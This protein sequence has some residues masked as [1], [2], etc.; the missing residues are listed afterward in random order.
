MRYR[1]RMEGSTMAAHERYRMNIPAAP[2]LAFAA[3]ALCTLSACDDEH[4]DAGPMRSES[5]DIESF[6]SID[7]EGAARL[8][9]TVGKP[10]SLTLEGRER[11]IERVSASVRGDT[12]YIKTKPKDW[13]FSP[14]RQ[15]LTINISVPRLDSL[16]VEGGNDVRLTGFAGGESKIRTTGAANIKAE[17]RLEEL[18]VQMSGAGH[19]DFSQLIADEAK[20]TV[21]GV[22]SVIVHPKD[23][24]NA[25]MNGIGAILYTGS[26]REVNT[27]MNGLGTIGRRDSGTS[28]ADDDEEQE[29]VE[30]EKEIDPR[31]L[32]PEYD[33]RQQ[34]K[35]SDTTELI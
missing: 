31:K 20:V 29:Q 2:R 32:Q 18:T 6:D 1:F 7:M 33:D 10:A 4:V 14:G 15:R 27:R 30:K 25:T 24:L 21:D 3:V 35:K 12:L 28:R 26:P 34:K 23:T 16:K 5:R 19:A 11:S 17:G 13:M 9:I 8:Q 22:G